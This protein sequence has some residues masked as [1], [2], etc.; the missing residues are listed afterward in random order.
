MEGINKKR[1]TV[2]FSDFSNTLIQ[3][4]QLETRKSLANSGEVLGKK[5][6][7]SLE[8]GTSPLLPNSDGIVYVKPVWNITSGKICRNITLLALLERQAEL[9][10]NETAFVTYNSIYR[11]NKKGIKTAK[12]E[13]ELGLNITGVSNGLLKTSRWFNLSQLTNSKA[14]L[15]FCGKQ[16][17]LEKKS[18]IPLYC[19]AQ[20]H[21]DYLA[22]ALAAITTNTPLVVNK[23]QKEA[24][25]HDA[26]LN[27]SKNRL[28]VY[29]MANKAWKKA[30]RYIASINEIARPHHKANK[31]REING[32]SR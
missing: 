15:D 18:S 2:S 5:L 16:F 11:A 3:K 29:H 10:T 32:I 26:V 20:N 4:A 19:N 6:I 22:Q 17:T 7:H 8:N 14:L 21:I 27:L 13:G 28:A 30:E 12:R 23:E 9:K 24:F 1:N 25:V 31:T